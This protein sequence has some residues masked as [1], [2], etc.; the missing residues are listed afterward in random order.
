MAMNIERVAV[1]DLTPSPRNARTHDNR[2]IRQ[3]AESIKSF[4]FTNPLLIDENNNIIAGHGRLKAAK[5]LDMT[6]VPVIR[7]TNLADAQKR[8]LMLAD[9]KIAANAGWD[10]DLLADELADLSSMDLDFSLDATG[11]EMG[12]IDLLIEEKEPSKPQNEEAVPSPDRSQPIITKYGDL[13]LLGRHRV[14]CGDARHASD[15]E[16]LMNGKRAA[17]GFTDPPYNV[18]IDGH[19]CGK[20]QIKHHE[21]AEASG[22]MS[23]DE[24]TAFL[25]ESFALSAANCKNGAVWFACMDWRHVGEM[26]AAG[27]AAFDAFLNICVWTKTNGGMGSL[28]R[29]QHE[30]VFV[31]RKGNDRHRNNVQLGRFGRNRTNVWIYP[32]VNTFRAGRMEELAAHPTAKPVAMIKDAML[33]V[34][35]RGDIVLDPF[36]GAGATVIAA[37]RCDRVAYGLEIDPTYVDVILRRWRTET[38]EE[39]TRAA[40]GRHLYDLEQEGEAGQ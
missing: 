21:F 4:G 9:N 14:L 23:P 29:S 13:W 5:R 19:V 22:E 15:Y 28:Y 26:T 35:R 1:R 37:E 17:M 38:G 3:L 16:C 2:Q 25:K 30:L 34:S 24:F 32:G 18:A 7:A 39:P 8:A 31:F 12:E 11:F 40:D 27:T 20:G 36:L 33:D 6:E 10:L